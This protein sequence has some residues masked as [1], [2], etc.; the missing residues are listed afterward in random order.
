MTEDLRVGTVLPEFVVDAVDAERIRQF[1]LILDDPNPIHFDLEA[2]ARA[3]LGDRAVNQG[4]ATMAYIVDMIARWRG[5]RRAL[6]GIDCRFRDNVRAGDTVTAGGVIT[7]VLGES[8]GGLRV[9]CDVWADRGDGRRVVDGTALVSV[10]PA[11]I[12]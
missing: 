8:T 10:D 3:G 4:G 11:Q 7:E 1:A 9:R 6:L 5:T 12:R 2:V